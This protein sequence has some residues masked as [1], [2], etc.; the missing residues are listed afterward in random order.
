MPAIFCGA[1]ESLMVEAHELTEEHMKWLLVLATPKKSFLAKTAPRAV[2]D[3]LLEMG[4]V[5]VVHGLARTTPEGKAELVRQI[6]RARPM[7]TSDS[8]WH[9]V[10]H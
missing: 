2:Q 8:A 5:A 9:P 6:L 10:D 1:E 3:T 4:L 7:Q